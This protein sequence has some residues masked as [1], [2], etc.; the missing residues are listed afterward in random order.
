M[1]FDRVT[2]VPC[3]IPPV[4]PQDNRCADSAFN[5]SHPSLCQNQ[6]ALIVKPSVAMICQLESI[7]FRVFE[8]VNG[9]EAEVTDGLVFQSSNP[10]VF[11]VG[12]NRGAGTGLTPGDV[13]ITVTRNGI[14]ATATVS[15]LQGTNCC[16]DVNVWTAM[17]LDNSRSASLSFGV[18][19]YGT[20]LDFAKAVGNSYGG[21]ILEVLNVPKD[22][23]KVWSLN[24]AVVGE[25]AT[26]SQVEAD[27]MAAVTGVTQTLEKTDL[28]LA[29]TT[30]TNDLITAT[31][32][33]RIL[34][35]ISDGEQ[36]VNTNRQAVIDAAA[37]FRA[38]G[39]IVVSVG[40]RASGLGYDLLER[41][42]TP[43]FFLNATT[44]SYAEVL[45][46]LSYLK[47]LLCAGQCVPVG[48][49]YINAPQLN[50]SS[51]TNWEVLQGQVNLIGP[52]LLDLQPGNGLYV[53]M[54]HGSPAQIRTI[55]PFSIV[56][57]RTYRISFRAAGN[58]RQSLSQYLKVFIRQVGAND[59]DPNIFE[60]SAS[61]AWNQNFTQFSF[62]F[63]ATSS[64]SV[65]LYF[66]QLYSGA[67]PT[68]GNLLD[69]VVFEDI[70]NLTTLLSDDFDD[71]NV[72]Y[73]P[74][75]C[76]VGTNW[77]LLNDGAVAFQEILTPLMTSNTT[78]SGEVTADPSNADGFNAF[79]RD[80]D[81]IWPYTVTSPLPNFIKYAFPS[82]KTV[83]TYSIRNRFDD[84]F[85][86]PK[87][88]VLE[89]SN[90]DS[91]WAVLDNQLDVVW[92]GRE[93]KSF[94]VSSPGSYR[95]YR[96]TITENSTLATFH[97]AEIVFIG[98]TD[99]FYGNYGYMYDYNCY[100]DPD[101]ASG[102]PGAQLPDAS[103][104]PDV[105]TGS[106][107]PVSY[108]STRSACVSCP[109]GFLNLSE[110]LVPLMTGASTPSGVASAS[111]SADAGA[112]PAWR[113]FDR[114]ITTTWQSNTA[115]GLPQWLQYQLPAAKT[116]RYYSV[117]IFV[118]IAAPAAWQF[119]GS[120]D[121]SSWTT[122]DTRSD[123]A[124]YYQE[125]KFFKITTPQSFLYYRIYMTELVDSTGQ[126][127]A[128]P[129]IILT[130]FNLI[131]EA[132]ANVCKSAT[133]TSY[134]S[135][136][137]ADQQALAAATALAQ[138]ELN[139]VTSYTATVSHTA[140]CTTGFGND[141]TKSV[142]AISLNSQQEATDAATAAATA[143]A[144]S[145][146]DCT[147]SNNGQAMAI[148]GSGA[149][150]KARPYPSVLFE[151]TSGIIASVEVAINGLTTRFSR[152]ISIILVS[153]AGTPV[154]LMR[155]CGNDTAIGPL[156]LI[157]DDTAVGFLPQQPAGP[158]VAGTFKPSAFVFVIVFP[159]ATGPNP[160]P[161]P[162]IASSLTLA[163]F[164][165]QQRQGAWS[166]YVYTGVGGDSLAGTIS[167]WDLAITTA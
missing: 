23:V 122:L 110:L 13:T 76:G 39:G 148:N 51:F 56:A 100:G 36:T 158:I 82:E 120:N 134:V 145:E 71:E 154:V 152:H 53:E 12:V 114:D 5:L 2:I 38:A 15:V 26:F 25:T 86:D 167:G 30:I 117:Q 68:I 109:S 147:L 116:V 92:A 32:D 48:D 136:G 78:P 151:S 85:Y 3:I 57:G 41:V 95:Y 49:S 89:G 141:V 35:L 108:T 58:Q 163:A 9:L 119:Q 96:L 79:D 20:R 87:D 7:Q 165:G 8:Y 104:L 140:R 133:R 62:S 166:L 74:P 156:D 65:R 61:Q 118:A 55:D 131:G 31:A 84:N 94:T 128:D 70:T 101:C 97:I 16:D 54:A 18:A 11:V 124:W 93:T 75:T 91:T 6:P 149:G 29:F 137:D 80:D 102:V 106:I 17:I 90:D 107:V 142:T 19:A 123:I 63:N 83:R 33:R 43:G 144:E 1:I 121:G 157:F 47:S 72:V 150:I 115:F 81:S 138:A 153:P 125:K 59:S 162:Q 27:V 52:G 24:S 34:L 88:W 139:C 10:S 135:Q 98:D 129:R 4:V 28:L 164:V 159:S 113:A 46:Q 155:G 67:A 111:S 44:V 14:S 60:Q 105:E 45:A 73:I 130:E 112:V 132:V 50:F 22:A 66:Q 103:P 64:L 146:L 21:N 40:L 69:S 42:S 77:V 126:G 127:F 143:E 99:T 37:L 160:A 161:A